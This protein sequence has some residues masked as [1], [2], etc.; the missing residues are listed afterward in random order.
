MPPTPQQLEVA[1]N[2]LTDD[3][4]I[5]NNVSKDLGAAKQ[6]ASDL[7]LTALHFSYIGDKLGM[8]ELYRKIQEKMVRLLGEG[9][10]HD[11]EVASA[12]IAVRTT[13][14]QEEQEGVHRMKGV[15]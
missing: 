8:T 15:W 13:Y 9:E 2:A 6:A 5:W 7:D 14:E 11:A 1:L 3:A 4:G 12:L 10:Q